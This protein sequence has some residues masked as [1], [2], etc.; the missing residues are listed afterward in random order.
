M[1][2]VVSGVLVVGV[3][4]TIDASRVAQQHLFPG[5]SKLARIFQCNILRI[6]ID[7]ILGYI[8]LRLSFVCV[9]ICFPGG[10]ANWCIGDVSLKISC[11][12]C[13]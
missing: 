3:E 5:Q 2:Y 6:L 12:Y 8:N 10:V 4:Q 13:I 9:K 11:L 7:S 1:S